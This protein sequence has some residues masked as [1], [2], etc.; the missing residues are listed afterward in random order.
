MGHVK[1]NKLMFLS[2]SQVHFIKHLLLLLYTMFAVQ[3]PLPLTHKHIALALSS[4]QH[5]TM[6][7][8][9]I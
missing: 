4:A 2:Y 7:V 6:S 8:T 5:S 3:L 9:N 1:T